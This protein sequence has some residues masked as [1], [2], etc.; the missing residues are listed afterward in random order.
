[1]AGIQVVLLRKSDGCQDS[2]WVL[3][4]DPSRIAHVIGLPHLSEQYPPKPT[5]GVTL[6]QEVLSAQRT[7]IFLFCLDHSCSYRVRLSIS[8][9]QM[10]S[11]ADAASRRMAFLPSHRRTL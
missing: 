10:I 9:D 5:P 7:W 3:T 11:K 8:A 1:M 6:L 2:L 4:S